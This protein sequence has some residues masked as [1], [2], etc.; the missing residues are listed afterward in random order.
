MERELCGDDITPC[1]AARA[2]CISSGEPQL[3]VNVFVNKLKPFKSEIMG[4]ASPS[5]IFLKNA[6]GVIERSGAYSLDGMPPATTKFSPVTYEASSE[7][8]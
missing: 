6:Q 1:C 2:N 4:W 3:T 8:R 5:S 7:T